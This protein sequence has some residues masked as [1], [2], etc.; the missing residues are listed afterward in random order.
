MLKHEL[1]LANGTVLTSGPDAGRDAIRSVSLTEQVNTET[2]L[3][4]GAVCAACA[5]IELWAPQN[6]LRIDPGDELTLRRLDTDTGTAQTVGI[7][8]AEQPVKVSANVCRVTAYDRVI[9]LDRDLSPWLRAHQADF[10]MALAAL[11]QQVCAV[12]GVPLADDLP[13][14]LPQANYRVPRFYAD[15]L[16]GRQILGWAG[17]I[18]CRFAR[19]T[20]Q[21]TLTFGWYAAGGTDNAIGP[22]AVSVPTVL[23]LAG[24]TLRTARQEVW[25]FLRTPAPYLQG[26]LRYETYETAPLDKVQIRQSD[27]DVG[28][29]YP[30]DAAGTNALVLQSNLLLTAESAD[31]IRPVAQYLFETL[32]TVRYTPLSVRVQAAGGFLPRAGSIL[33]VQDAY[34]RQYT[35][36]VMRCTLAGQTLTLEATGNARRDSVAAVNEKTYT[37]LQGKMLEI[38]ADIDGLNIKASELAGNYTELNLDVEGL[39]ARTENLEGDY[40]QLDMTVDGLSARTQNLEGD[41]TQLDMTVGGLSAR[42][43]NLE[44]DYTQMDMTVGG[45]SARTQNLEGDA[46]RLQQTVDGLDLTVVKKGQVRTQ[47][48]ADADSVTINSGL[49][50]FTANTLAIDSSNFQLTPQ[51]NVTAN[52]SFSSQSGELRSAVLNGGFFSYFGGELCSAIYG[53]TE[54]GQDMGSMRCYGLTNSGGRHEFAVLRAGTDG[55]QFALTDANGEQNVQITGGVLI[56]RGLG[57]SGEKNRLVETGYGT[58]KLHTL[59]SP[60]PRFADFGTGVCDENGLCVV[61]LDPRFAETV[62]ACQAPQWQITPTAPGVLWVEPGWQATVHGAPGQTFAWMV[63]APQRDYEDQ[64]LERWD[65]LNRPEQAAARA[66]LPAQNPADCAVE[67]VLWQDIAREMTRQQSNQQKLQEGTA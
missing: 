41:Y 21:G 20:P 2:D 60:Q 40:T 35:F 66:L 27:S 10:P 33:T 1:V 14:T 36:P 50:H 8:R 15:G 44:G 16:T 64:Y 3:C 29:I 12:C 59:E 5:E 53:Y 63:S 17:Q 62:S 58:L 24:E 13:A 52:G 67:T 7:F 56:A 65:A 49:V 28:V 26:G 22:G 43:Q 51:G 39:S 9:L 48:A 34:G 47:F 54:N 23:R 18:A 42:T 55:G 45:L 4:P 19:M 32:R 61:A 37:N 11:V 30:P 6:A 57:I 31:A 38:R 25:R 46:T